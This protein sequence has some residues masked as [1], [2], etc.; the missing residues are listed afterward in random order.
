MVK[1]IL[2]LST[3]LLLT[4]IPNINVNASNYRGNLTT[5]LVRYYGANNTQVSVSNGATGAIVR[6]Y[7]MAIYFNV[8]TYYD[9]GGD[10]YAIFTG[11]TYVDDVAA[12]TTTGSQFNTTIEPYILTDSATEN[13]NSCFFSSVS[14]SFSPNGWST[15][16]WVVSCKLDNVLHNGTYRNILYFTVSNGRN[17]DYT[18]MVTTLDSD[19]YLVSNPFDNEGQSVIN[20]ITNQT[21]SITNNQNQN[22]QDIINNQ[23]SNTQDVIDNQNQNTQDQID[24][25]KVCKIIDNQNIILNDRYLIS[26]GNTSAS[27]SSYGI[28]DYINIYNS[29][30][31]RLSSYGNSPSLCYYN[32]N[33]QLISC[34][35]YSS[36]TNNSLTI[37]TDAYYVRFSIN[38]NQNKP[39]FKICQ[40]GNQALNDSVNNLNDTLNSEQS[41]N[42]NQ[43][44]QDMDDMVASDTPI[45]DLIT[46]PL[47]LINA[48]ING[49]GATCSPVNLGSL[50]GTNLTIPCI[51]IQQHIGSNLWNIIDILCCIFLCYEIGMLFISAFDG[52]TSL[53]DDF[54]GLYQPKHAYTGYVPKHGGGN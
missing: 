6:P 1:K 46:M 27:D 52:I 21:T 31:E 23:D 35:P 17:G 2:F 50:L 14:N 40:N 16:S 37:P 5:D 34:L 7:R 53:R 32:V 11:R 25:Q 19:F 30:I 38:Y 36:I 39:Q 49:I 48:Y 10:Y 42:T 8:N 43:D 44:I 24:S 29:T 33:R 3:F 4:I 28:T 26:N 9:F 22:T 18:N 13:P 20:S 12:D 41:P 47:T 54:E 15:I 51:N 45:S